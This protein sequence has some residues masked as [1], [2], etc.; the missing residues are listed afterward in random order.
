MESTNDV[1]LSK[2]LEENPNFWEKIMVKLINAWESLNYWGARPGC[3]PES[4][5]M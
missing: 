2:I 1:D 4:T 5:P 3:P